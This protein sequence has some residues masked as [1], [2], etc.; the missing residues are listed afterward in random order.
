MAINISLTIGI[1]VKKRRYE[2]ATRYFALIIG[3][4]Y[5]LVG[6]VGLLGLMLAPYA[7]PPLVLKAQ[8]GMLMGLFPVNVLHNIVHL[9]IGLVGIASYR[10]YNGSRNFSRGLAIL[11]AL[12]AVLGLL[13]FTNTTFGLIPLHSHDIWLHAAT[14]LIAAYFGFAAPEQGEQVSTSSRR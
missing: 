5:T 9:A 14:A 10:S 2:M 4:V 11:Y 8:Q 13:P 6:V 7:G 3:I 1:P 12:L